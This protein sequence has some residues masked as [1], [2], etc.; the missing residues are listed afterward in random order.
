MPKTKTLKRDDAI[1]C[2]KFSIENASETT[3]LPVLL[4]GSHGVGKTEIVKQVAKEMDYNVTIL[5]LA[6]QD[7][8][9]LIGRPVTET[10][11]GVEVQRW[12]VPSWL[13]DAKKLSEQNGKPTLFFLDE[14]NR[15][16]RLVL[17]A[18]LPFLIEGIL[19]THK[20]GPKDAVIAAAN[21]ANEN[22][23]VNELTDKAL[24]NRLGHIVLSPTVSEYIEYLR[25]IGMDNVTIDVI[26]KNNEFA[27]IPEIELAFE[28]EPSRRS[29]VNIMSKIGK[30]PKKWIADNAPKI[31]ETYLGESFALKWCEAYAVGDK[32]ITLDMIQAYDA[33][34]SDIEEALTTT[35]DGR[36]TVRIDILTK[37]TDLLKQHIQDNAGVTIKDLSYMIKFFETPIIP[38]EHCE[39]FFTTNK[40]IRDSML[41]PDVNLELGKFFDKKKILNASGLANVW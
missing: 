15:G 9:D 33:Y 12:A 25:H 40:H 18:M 8:I 6:T 31:I 21:P 41:S 27:K 14:F 20:I 36:R 28:V 7:I 35:I 13:H 22:Y 38:T 24:L 23:E 37:A 32:S 29:I 4:W 16:P 26:K 2:I 39:N 30:K 17:A 34:K 10:V 1:E 3:K 19:H 11:D 5:H